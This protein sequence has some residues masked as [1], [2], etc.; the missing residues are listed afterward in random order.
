MSSEMTFKLRAVVVFL[1]NLASLQK[2]NIM[3]IDL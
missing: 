3:L 2:Q 1:N